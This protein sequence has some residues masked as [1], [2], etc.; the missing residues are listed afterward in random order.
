M[1]Q[2]KEALTYG[3]KQ[4]NQ[5]NVRPMYCIGNLLCQKML[6]NS[7]FSMLMSRPEVFQCCFLNGGETI[8]RLLKHVC[9]IALPNESYWIDKD[10]RF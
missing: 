10:D 4:S 3:N 2:I 9:V 6:M 8:M 7:W 1:I 5:Y